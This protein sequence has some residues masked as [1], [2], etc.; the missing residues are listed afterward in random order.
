MFC[1]SVA[2]NMF[3]AKKRDIFQ[4]F[5]KHSWCGEPASCKTCLGIIASMVWCSPVKANAPC[6]HKIIPLWAL[7]HPLNAQETAQIRQQGIQ[8]EAMQM[9]QATYFVFINSNWQCVTRSGKC[10]FNQEMNS[11]ENTK[12]PMETRSNEDRETPDCNSN[13]CSFID[14]DGYL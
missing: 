12:Q 10:I 3:T 4:F 2:G 8:A 1:P 9:S 11:E 6:W 7:C 5:P 14:F 13:E